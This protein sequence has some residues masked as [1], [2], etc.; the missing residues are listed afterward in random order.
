M[1]PKNH[2]IRWLI[3][4]SDSV[5]VDE[6]RDYFLR[7]ADGRLPSISTHSHYYF[8]PSFLVVVLIIC[9]GDIWEGLFNS[10]F[11]DVVIIPLMISLKDTNI[12]VGVIIPKECDLNLPVKHGHQIKYV[13]GRIYSTFTAQLVGRQA[14]SFVYPAGDGQF[15]GTKNASLI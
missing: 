8:I 15:Y 2:F 3:T 12:L 1:A 11:I 7:L 6:R 14:G 5:E 4:H 13:G 10:W 9:Q